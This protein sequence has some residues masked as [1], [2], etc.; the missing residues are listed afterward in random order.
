[1]IMIH[2]FCFCFCLLMG[3]VI[4]KGRRDISSFCFT[5]TRRPL[6]SGRGTFLVQYHKCV[7][8]Y[9]IISIAMAMR[10]CPDCVAVCSSVCGI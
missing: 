6:R 4:T 2:G 3:F 10:T 8:Y 5:I 9:R 1:M 7:L